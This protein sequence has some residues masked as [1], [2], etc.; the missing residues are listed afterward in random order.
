[1]PSFKLSTCV[2]HRAGRETETV[3]FNGSSLN[4]KFEQNIFQ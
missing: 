4:F 3:G 1:M 2:K